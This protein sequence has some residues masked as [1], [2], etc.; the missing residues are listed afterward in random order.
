MNLDTNYHSDE[1]EKETALPGPGAGGIFLVFR[2]ANLMRRK[3]SIFFMKAPASALAGILTLLFWTAGVSALPPE[4]ER[5]SEDSRWEESIAAFAAA[6]RQQAPPPGGVVFVGSSSIRLWSDL[7]TE[8]SHARGI[9]RRGFGGARMADCTR[10]VDRLVLPYTPRLIVV[11]A[12][13]NDLADGREPK[14]VFKDFVR[15]VDAVRKALPTTPIHYISIK[16]SPARAALISKVRE[17]NQLIQQ[18]V[19]G[20]SNLGYIDVFTP[21]LDAAGRPR[22]DLFRADALHLNNTGYKLWASI[23]APHVR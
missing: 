16:P 20:G 19:A 22:T 4:A 13:D 10:Y 6:D 1:M 17:T 11:Y 9:I 7:T 8:L 23:I 15:F 12:G 3:Y 21:M 18:F 5:S 2:F 14:D